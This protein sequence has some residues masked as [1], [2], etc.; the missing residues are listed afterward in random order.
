MNARKGREFRR[1]T[2]FDELLVIPRSGATRNLGIVEGWHDAF[3]CGRY[4][5]SPNY[6]SSCRQI[7]LHRVIDAKEES[8]GILHSP[9]FIR[10]GEMHDRTPVV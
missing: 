7:D 3:R 1:K 8:A 5:A 10:D 6:T 2:A 4:D 9:F